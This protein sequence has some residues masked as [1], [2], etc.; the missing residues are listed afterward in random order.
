MIIVTHAKNGV[1]YH[2]LLTLC[3]VVDFF[4]FLVHIFNPQRAKV[5]HKHAFGYQIH[6]WFAI[7]TNKSISQ[8]L[9]WSYKHIFFCD[10][11]QS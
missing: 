2:F 9:A 4:F 11:T 5:S 6:V 8:K 7:A 3:I 1:S 10:I